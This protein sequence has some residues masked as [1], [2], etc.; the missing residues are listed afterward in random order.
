MSANANGSKFD[1]PPFPESRNPTPLATSQRRRRKPEG[2]AHRATIWT[3]V[4]LTTV[5]LVGIGCQGRSRQVPAPGSEVDQGVTV[6]TNARFI[7]PVNGATVDSTFTVVMA[8]DNMEIDPAGEAKVGSGHYHIL[9]DVPFVDEG[10][11]IPTDANH[12][13]FGT[14]A[15]TVDI[16]LPA[17]P[18]TLR[19]QVANGVHIAYDSAEFGDAIS[20]TVR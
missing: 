6:A 8:V 19:L 15:S 4:A 14:G 5:T 16:T 2:T 18:H 7:E 13:H 12:L 1:M 9:V 20:V 17:G 10:L 3:V 11:I